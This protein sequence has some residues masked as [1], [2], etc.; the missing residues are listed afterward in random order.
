[1]DG[2]RILQ[3]AATRKDTP[4]DLPPDGV[5]TLDCSL[6]VLKTFADAGLPFLP[7]VRTAEQ[8][9][10]ACEPVE[11]KDVQPGDLLFFEH[12]YEPN[13]A[14]GPDG[15]VASHI[16][17]SLG[18]GTRQV[19]DANDGRGNVGITNIGSSYWQ[20]KLLSAGR[21]KVDA[22]PV[23]APSGHR[24]R[25]TGTE[26]RGVNVREQPD[27][28]SRRVGGLEEGATVDAGEH[29]WRPVKT[30]VVEGWVA[31]EYLE[32]VPPDEPGATSG[33]FSAQQVAEVLGAPLANV[34]RHLPAI[35]AALDELGIGDR[36]TATAALATIGVEVGSFLPIEEYRNADGSIP[37]YWYRYGGGPL[38]HGRGFI[39]LT[40]L[41]NYQ[42]FGDALGV[43]LAGNP[44]LALDPTI[45]ARVLALYFKEHNIPALANM[46]DWYATRLAVN[47]GDTGWQKYADYIDAFE[48]LP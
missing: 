43:D 38:Y 23:P 11:L 39:Q 14:P 21:P 27:A 47:G 7:G 46:P 3:A 30:G 25:V 18:A 32:E 44:N 26:G 19:W 33:H 40:H 37:N 15:H 35:Y 9:R 29:A 17:I 34:E 16:G 41:S 36:A 28:N 13:E 20:G 42:H 24:M 31:A 10:Q 48:A 2:Q 6:Y 45:A 22:Q 1:M 8:I 12:T 5:H 4:Y